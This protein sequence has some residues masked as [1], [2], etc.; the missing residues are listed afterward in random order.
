MKT[1]F[2]L[3]FIVTASLFC[4]SF[5]VAQTGVEASSSDE[6][7]DQVKKSRP[8]KKTKADTGK[9]DGS[10]RE[11][12][13]LDNTYAY[14]YALVIDSNPAVLLHPPFESLQPAGGMFQWDFAL[15]H[16]ALSHAFDQTVSINSERYEAYITNIDIGMRVHAPIEYFQPFAGAGV[17]IGWMAVSNPIYRKSQGLFAATEGG[18]SGTWGHYFE[19]G[20]DVLF[21]LTRSLAMGFRIDL[22]ASKLQTQSFGEFGGA[23][24]N[25]YRL[26]PF[27]GIVFA[28]GRLGD[29]R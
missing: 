10:A 12:S 29:L 9:S 1:K 6:S 25:A 3:S 20:S 15:I 8:K 16:L 23:S 28:S 2:I 17:S 26:Q 18:I 5:S 14:K 13:F 24:L 22:R 4:G 21:K 27:V 11:E 7:L 19:I